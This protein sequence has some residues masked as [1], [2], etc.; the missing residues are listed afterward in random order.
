VR[1]RQA[2]SSIRTALHE[3]LADSRPSAPALIV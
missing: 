1:R 2:I 3:L